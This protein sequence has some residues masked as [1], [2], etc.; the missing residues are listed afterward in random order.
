MQRTSYD[1]H[2][3]NFL[4]TLAGAYAVARRFDDAVNAAQEALKLAR[5]AGDQGSADRIRKMLEIFKRL[6]TDNRE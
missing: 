1:V 2:R 3:R 6:E 4:K 5:A